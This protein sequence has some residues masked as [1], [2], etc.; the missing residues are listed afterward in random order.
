MIW[1]CFVCSKTYQTEGGFYNHLCKKHGIS[2]AKN[3]TLKMQ[4]RS[5]PPIKME[6]TVDPNDEEDDDADD[7]DNTGEENQNKQ[8]DGKKTSDNSPTRRSPR[9]RKPTATVSKPPDSSQ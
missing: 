4:K 6:F 7:D 1:Q 8:Q 2:R 9:N 3:N 5:E